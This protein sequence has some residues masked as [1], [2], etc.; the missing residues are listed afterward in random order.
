M[1]SSVDI[2]QCLQRWKAGDRAALD[3]LAVLVQG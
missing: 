1:R 2:T 3:E